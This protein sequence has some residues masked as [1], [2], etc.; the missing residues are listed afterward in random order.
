MQDQIQKI[1]T[2]L[3][4]LDPELK[5]DEKR[6]EIIVREL[7]V[8]RPNTSLDP[9][10]V[11]NLRR[12]LI[13]KMESKT[14]KPWYLSWAEQRNWTFALAG[15]SVFLFA[16]VVWSEVGPRNIGN[17]SL[18]L[19]PRIAAVGDRAFGSLTNQAPAYG[20]GG[21]GNNVQSF[22][23][24]DSARSIL[25]YPQD[26]I[27][28]AFKY[29]G[30]EL[31]SSIWQ[32]MTVLKRQKGTYGRELANAFNNRQFG[33]LNLGSLNNLT[34]DN[35]FLKEDKENGYNIYISLWEGTV[36][37][38]PNSRWSL[39]T[40]KCSERGC[41]P[42]P[43]PKLEDFP[44]DSEV[45]RIANEFLQE[46][47]I[48]RGAFGEGIV[49]NDWKRISPAEGGVEPQYL[50]SQL[51]VTYPLRV[52]DKDVFYAYGARYGLQV[53]VDVLERKVV[54][55]NELVLPVYDSSGYALT[56]DSARILRSAENGG[57]S[58][59]GFS[60]SGKKETIEIST[61]EVVYI[62][63]YSYTGNE[64]QDLLVPALAFPVVNQATDSKFTQTHI[65]VPVV[66]EVLNDLEKQK[67][68]PATIMR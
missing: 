39:F 7:L 19:S 20:L 36:T 32:D 50:P 18:S 21:G 30:N 8:R 65:V 60:G 34:V 31:D 23:E 40:E 51:V 37:L 62:R 59:F 56:K 5:K 64:A 38:S 2:D 29:T 52:Q 48:D 6:V 67:E 57:A 28:Y 35:I 13:Q 42:R 15:I 1:L 22:K 12:E 44:A 4:L 33:L 26:L 43:Q 66:E 24:G 63:Q 61:P 41:E 14:S 3:Y 17:L 49:N 58:Y 68:N 16:W 45:V 55:V 25:P 27:S 46:K 53:S 10:F 54:G 9:L 47:G 11:A